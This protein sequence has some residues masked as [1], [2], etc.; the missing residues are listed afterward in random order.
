M[1]KR[2]N[3]QSDRLL[4]CIGVTTPLGMVKVGFSPWGVRRLWLPGTFAGCSGEGERGVC[5][6]GE[7]K[8]EGKCKELGIMCTGVNIEPVEGLLSTFDST[9]VDLAVRWLRSYFYQNDGT[10][11]MPVRLVLTRG[12]GEWANKHRC[13]D[14]AENIL[15][16]DISCTTIFQEEVWR[17]LLLIPTGA[18]STYGEVAKRIG[19]PKAVRATGSACGANPLPLFIPCHRVVAADG[20]LGGFMGGTENKIRLLQM[21]GVERG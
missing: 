14:R 13:I 11:G 19:R 8:A 18:V 6:T 7:S 12:E 9:Y 16:L 10:K 2:P 17:A 3:G 1:T 4:H 21:E 20:G 5:I 15:P